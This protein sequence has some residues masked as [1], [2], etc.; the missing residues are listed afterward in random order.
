MPARV[1]VISGSTGGGSAAKCMHVVVDRPW[2]FPCCWAETWFLAER[3]SAQ[4]SSQH[5]SWLPS[6]GGPGREQMREGEQGR[7]EFVGDLILV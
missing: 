4:E 2:V 3:P 1:A 5:G 6:E 7:V